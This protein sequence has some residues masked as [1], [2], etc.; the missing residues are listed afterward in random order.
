[1]KCVCMCVCVCVCVL[2]TQLSP[3][4]CNSMTITL[5]APLSMGYPK[6]EY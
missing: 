4:L 2:V 5:Q 3:T 1:M 6:Q